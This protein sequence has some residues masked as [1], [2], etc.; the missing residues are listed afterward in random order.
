MSQYE[1]SIMYTFLYNKIQ[2][3]K[4]DCQPHN[5]LNVEQHISN[6]YKCQKFFF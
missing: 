5:I 3:Y 6:S 2:I 1:I 4:K